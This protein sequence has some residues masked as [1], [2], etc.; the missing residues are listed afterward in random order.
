M[1]ESTDDPRDYRGG[2]R[3]PE[4][5][6][7]GG[8]D[9]EGIVPREMLDDPGPRDADPQDLKDDVMGEVTREPKDD[10]Q[11]DPSSGDDADATNR[12]DSANTD[13]WHTDPATVAGDTG[14]G[15]A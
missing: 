10:I 3:E 7:G 9:N 1:A 6:K 2:V 15:K 12:D 13:T 5:A 14:E 4:E 8:A 11:I